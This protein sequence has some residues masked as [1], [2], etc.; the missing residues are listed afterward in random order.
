MKLDFISKLN[1]SL[2][3]KLNI[4]ELSGKVLK[5]PEV[6]FNIILAFVTL[7]IVVSINNGFSRKAAFLRNRLENQKA[8]NV[9]I[10]KFRELAERFNNYRKDFPDEVNVFTAINKINEVA[11]RTGCQ[12][13]SI[14]PTETKERPGYVTHFF[15]IKLETNY[16]ILANFVKK[17]EA[18]K[19]FRILDLDISSL[20]T[21]DE[22][23]GRQLQRLSVDMTL[24]AI[25]LKK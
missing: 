1:I 8:I 2:I 22:V 23:N 10:Q 14:T 6:A 15:N 4:R 24:S 20:S 19:V 7:L 18:Q 9:S 25:A 12:V 5:R 11:E 13:V 21:V 17:L 3:P 16:P